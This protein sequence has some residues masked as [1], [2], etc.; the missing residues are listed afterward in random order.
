MCALGKHGDERVDVVRSQASDVAVHQLAELGVA[1]RP[2]RLLLGL[3]PYAVL[4]RRP[5]ALKGP[6]DR[7]EGPVLGPVPLELAYL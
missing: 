3:F 5:H 6:V 1:K 2:H 4:D 7:C